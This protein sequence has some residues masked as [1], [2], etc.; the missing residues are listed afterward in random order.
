M[1][2][3]PAT[4]I[5]PLDVDLDRYVEL[6]LDLE[7]FTPV[8]R[9]LRIRRGKRPT[10]PTRTGLDGMAKWLSEHGWQSVVETNISPYPTERGEDLKRLSPAL[11]SRHIFHELIQLLAPRVLVLHGEDSL[12]EFITSVAPQLGRGSRGFAA[13]VNEFPHLGQYRWQ[14]GE[15]ADIFVCPHLRFFGHSGGTRFSSLKRALTAHFPS[16]QNPTQQRRPDA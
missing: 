6:L 11:Q 14:T 16:G 5:G 12:S 10:S 4:P 13:L 9:Q 2:L 1:G 15:V 8:Y 3:N 7:A